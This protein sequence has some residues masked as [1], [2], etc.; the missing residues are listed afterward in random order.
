MNNLVMKRI[1]IYI[2]EL[3]VSRWKP[4]K[5]RLIDGPDILKYAEMNE[6]AFFKLYGV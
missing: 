3:S 2:K 5:Y 6:E 1:D 4:T